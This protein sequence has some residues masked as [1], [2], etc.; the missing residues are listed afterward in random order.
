MANIHG[1][2]SGRNAN[3]RRSA[4]E[5]NNEDLD[6]LF[7]TNSKTTD[8][9]GESFLDMLKINL[10]PRLTLFSFAVCMMIVLTIAFSAQMII[11]GIEGTGSLLEAKMGP[12]TKSFTVVADKNLLKPAMAW[13][14]HRDL[15]ALFGSLLLLLIWVGSMNTAFGFLLTLAIFALGSFTGFL[16]AMLLLSPGE[17][18][19]GASPG[20][21]SLLG[22]SL[23]L[24]ILNWKLIEGARGGQIFYY[25]WMIIL[26]IMLSMMF[27]SS[28][29]AMLAQLGAILAGVSL[30]MG[31]GRAGGSEENAGYAKTTRIVGF[32]MF[33]V[34]LGTPLA[35]VLLRR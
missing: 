29:T 33:A 10:C 34:V 21:F 7:A 30:G 27:S 26:I 14:V 8:P 19:N 9:R 16:F 5:P 13:L 32:G 23:G 28:P 17:R 2:G 11:D 22:A 25:F 4:S 1:F 20:I 24:I 15:S 6:W 18:I 3:T 12:L 35:V 31:L